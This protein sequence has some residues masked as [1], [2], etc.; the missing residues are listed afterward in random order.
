MALLA[1]SISVTPSPDVQLLPAGEFAAQDGRPG[2]G[3]TWKLDDQAGQALAAALTAQSAKTAFAIDYDHQTLRADTNGQPAPAAGWATTFEWRAGKG[4]YATDVA[5]TEAALAHIKA[6]EYRYVSPVIAYDKKSGAVV[7]VQMAAIVNRPALVGMDPLGQALAA[8]LAAQFGAADDHPDPTPTERTMPQVIPAAVAAALA[9]KAD[10]GEADVLAAITALK[11]KAKAPAAAALSAPVVAALGLAAGAD[12]AAA[13][14]AITR[15]K[16]DPG[17]GATAIAALQ[18]EV[19]TLKAE[20]L[21]AKVEQVVDAALSAGKL[22]P[23]QRAWAVSMG[24]RELQLLTDYLASAP[25]LASL[26]SQTN[27][28]APAGSD[29]E[30]GEIDAAA[31][32]AKA[33]AWQAEQARNGITV[34]TAQAVAHVN[35]TPADKA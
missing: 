27:G 34:T 23:A 15:L 25:V 28:H 21:K 26:K 1:A 24:Q 8:R 6:G 5:W 29:S 9:C 18:A 14:A 7:G 22:V 33:V 31:L 17:Q 30:G 32:A 11:D 12:E 3:L 4:L 2:K 20:A 35:K 19:V 16:A 10:A 13:L